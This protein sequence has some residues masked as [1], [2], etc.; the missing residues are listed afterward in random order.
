MAFIFNRGDA[1]P[2]T[3]WD[4]ISN[5]ATA[6]ARL[7]AAGEILP[8]RRAGVLYRPPEPGKYPFIDA[9][10]SRLRGVLNEGEGATK[11]AHSVEEDEHGTRWVVL[12]DGNFED[13]TSSVY[14]VGN[15]ISIEADA[16]LLIAAVWSTHYAGSAAY[17]LFTYQRKTF[18]PFIPRGTD[19]RDHPNELALAKLMSRH[20]MTV[21]R[22]TEHWYPL[23]G[24]PF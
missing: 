7:Q 19:E 18:Y 8:G 23:W 5:V 17:W 9:L 16:S 24:I 20:G 4:A 3:D 22:S 15:A 2:K 1:P 6:E 21:E 14:T 11:T 10:E 13:L 12:D